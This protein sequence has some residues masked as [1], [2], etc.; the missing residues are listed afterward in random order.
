M[1][2]KTEFKQNKIGMI[3]GKFLPLHIGHIY[4]IIE[5]HSQADKLYVI[6]SSS[7]KR[8]K[9]ICELCHI[10]YMSA[11][12]R[13]SWIGEAF[14]DLENI[15]IINIE[16]DK[17]I[18]DYDWVDGANKIKQAIPEEI[19]HI[20][21]S[22]SSYTEIFKANYPNAKHIVIDEPR[23]KIDV[24]ATRI[25]NDPKSNWNYMPD[26]VRSFFVKKIVVV[27]TESSGKSTLVSKLAKFYNTNFAHEVGR[28]YCSKYG[29]QLTEEMFDRI[30][31]DHFI[32]HSDI[33]SKSNKIL[34]VDSEAIITKYYLDM[35]LNKKSEFL[36][37]I[38]KKQQFDLWLFLEPDIKWV[39]DGYRFAG[40]IKER[41]KNNNILKK[42]LSGYGIE[43]FSIFGNYSERFNNAVDIIEEQTR[44]AKI[45]VG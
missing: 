25:R 7:E 30:A 13:L 16:D 8:D 32:F 18:D 14:N 43:Y 38:I 6:L 29:N 42:M 28:D 22:E 10:K 39:S 21:S 35:Y 45:C 19:T 24:S 9:R 17:G 26:F 12:I 37:A 5:A 4:A 20:F 23:S 2:K 41:S 3:G 27:G 40:G 31:M 11:E 15:S 1:L 34:F 44:K 36:E 33:S